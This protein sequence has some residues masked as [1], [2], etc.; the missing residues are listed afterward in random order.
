MS[1]DDTFF[2]RFLD[3]TFNRPADGDPWYWTE[4]RELSRDYEKIL[5]SCTQLFESPARS[6][7]RYSSRQLDVGFQYMGSELGYLRLI[8]EPGV[9]LSIRQLTVR[10]M[11]PLF[12]DFF[13]FNPQDNTCFAWWRY[14]FAW[15]SPTGGNIYTQPFVVDALLTVLTSIIRIQSRQCV[16]SGLNGLGILAQVRSGEVMRIINEFLS[17]TPGISSEIRDYAVT[18][19]D[20]CGWIP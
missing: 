10:S 16:V 9:S 14:T 15:G 1:V 17:E 5:L 2:S 13:Q 20:S 18:C 11:L 12:R 3:W 7:A 19:R 4:S 8:F 6:L